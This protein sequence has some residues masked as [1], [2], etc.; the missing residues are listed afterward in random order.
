MKTILLVLFFA[1][2]TSVVKAEPLTEAERT[3]KYEAAISQHYNTALQQRQAQA[4]VLEGIPLGAT[5]SAGSL[6]YSLRDLDTS[7]PHNIT[8]AAGAAS[9]LLPH[10]SD[11][12]ASSILRS[13]G[14]R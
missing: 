11:W 4:S 2:A 5:L 3:A 14:W 9:S 1:S 12:T 10:V 6:A 13:M 8:G 7:N